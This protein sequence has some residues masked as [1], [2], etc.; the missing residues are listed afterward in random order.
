MAEQSN[1]GSVQLCMMRLATLENDG[2]PLPGSANLFVTDG[3]AKLEAT[4]VMTKGVDLELL[5]G[6]NAPAVL[7]KD[8]DRFKRYDL[9]LSLTYV[10]A[11]LEG[12][13]IGGEQYTSG[14]FTIG[15][16][17]PLQAAYAGSP[18]GVS[19]EFWTKH[20]VGGDQDVNYPYIRWVMPRA[21][22][23]W[24]KHT[25]DN[26]T[27]SRDYTGYTSQNPNWYNGP[28]N[29]WPYASDTQLMWAFTKTLP[30]PA[31]GAQTLVHS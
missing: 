1:G 20:I 18:Y 17:V 16:S 28:M 19:L 10:D 9:T 26:T 12:M 27:F 30:V 2:V 3:V 4:P 6:C 21:H 13:L 22:F 11:E 23:A 29:D 25:W 31:I 8:Q 5:N 7:Y 24:D 14:G 15:G